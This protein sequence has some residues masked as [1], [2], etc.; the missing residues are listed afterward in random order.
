MT[1][2]APRIYPWHLAQCLL[3]HLSSSTSAATVCA[4]A[5]ELYNRLQEKGFLKKGY[6]SHSLGQAYA[7]AK[8][9]ILNDMASEQEERAYIQALDKVL[10][11]HFPKYERKDPFKEGYRHEWVEFLARWLLNRHLEHSGVAF[12]PEDLRCEANGFLSK[13]FAG[14]FEV[15]NGLAPLLPASKAVPLAPIV[16]PNIPVQAPPLPGKHGTYGDWQQFV[17]Y[18]LDQEDYY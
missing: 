15:L 8:A 4:D 10:C 5:K 13:V 12:S 17:H 18:H 14:V 11:A 6:P 3:R 2:I 1:S 9:Q 16:L 7:R